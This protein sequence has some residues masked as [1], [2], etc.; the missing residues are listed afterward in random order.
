MFPLKNLARK[1]LITR[2]NANV[3]DN[4]LWT[5]M[6]ST[7]WI[8][9]FMINSLAPGKFEWYFKYAIFKQILVIDGWGISSKI[10]LIWMPLEFT[11]D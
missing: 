2:V 9:N 8:L 4:P 6:I 3:T 7:G 1:G 11:D 10:A 5:W